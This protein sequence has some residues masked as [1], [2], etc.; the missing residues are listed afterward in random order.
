MQIVD[1]DRFLI[2]FQVQQT[3][4]PEPASLALFGLGLL[5]LGVALRRRQS[6]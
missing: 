2:S 4:L 1:G 5:G 3:Q 6:L